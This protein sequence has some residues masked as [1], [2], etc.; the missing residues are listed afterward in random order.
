M[1]YATW[2]ETR[3]QLPYGRTSGE[4]DALCPECS[5]TRK[6]ENQREKCLSV[7]LGERTWYC[8]NCGWKGA[9]KADD[10]RGR[11]APPP[12]PAPKK[13]ELPSQGDL[14]PWV[15]DF[16]AER[17]IGVDV[18]R[19]N[20]V[21]AGQYNGHDAIVI[22]YRRNG[23]IVTA[24]FRFRQFDPNEKKRH[25]MED[26]TEKIP[27]GI[28]DCAG[29]SEVVIVEGEPDKFAVEQATGRTAVL[30]PPNGAKLS[31]ETLTKMIA[32]CGDAHVILAGDM[33]DD[34]EAMIARL[35]ERLGYDRCSRVKW[36]CKDANDTLIEYGPEVVEAFLNDA[37]PFP[38]SGVIMVDDISADID[39]LYD[40]GMPGGASTGWPKLDKFYTVKVGQLTI[41]T[42]APGSG[43]SVWTDAL[44]VNL[45]RRG[46]KAGICSPEQ[47]PLERHAAQLISVYNGKPFGA[48]PT[49]RMTREEKDAGKDWLK[50][51]CAF[52]LPEENTIEAV[53]ERGVALKRRMG[54]NAFV[55]D[56][57]TELDHTRPAGMTET[58]FI[59]ASLTKIRVFARNYACHVWVIAHPTKLRK[60]ESGGY[61]VATPYDISGS[62][63]WF[64]KADNCLSVWRN[65]GNEAQ[66]V[67]LHIQKIR[68]R[69]IGGIGMMQFRH[70]RLTGRYMEV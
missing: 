26:A 19:R 56:P 22:P 70:D 13:S 57:W 1:S 68:F 24:K 45:A 47:L 50:T 3:I 2:D 55:I 59:H 62:A 69:E 40:E 49:P 51:W 32:A 31:D 14:A 42:G 29:A 11:M 27:C 6:R 65:K 5:H 34:G 52:V 38:I 17:K 41:V 12:K 61:P 10:W 48:G 66:P 9:I 46:W 43:K 15:I 53:L 18:L 30:S 37:K 16:F 63:G 25:A 36:P 64:N 7:N 67:E 54:I 23:E 4:V 58:E 28:D 33:D 39:R 20:G 35:A 60:D 21:R 8:H 44:L